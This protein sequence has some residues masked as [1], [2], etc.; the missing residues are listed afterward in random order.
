MATIGDMA[1]DFALPNQ[2]G[3]IIRL[4]DFRGKKVVIF[5]FPQANTAGC[6]MQ[7]CAFRD[8]FPQIEADNAVVLGIST[9]DQKALKSWKQK[10]KLP[11]DLLSD[12]EHVVL[13]QLNCF[14]MSLF[15]LINIPRATRSYWVIDENGAIIDGQV[16]V[17]PKESVEKALATLKRFQSARA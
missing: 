16:G 13:D 2:D 1:P 10:R 14:G 7:A 6:T 3:K 4:S 11:Y 17:G 9:D 15:G 5:A 12:T 8:E